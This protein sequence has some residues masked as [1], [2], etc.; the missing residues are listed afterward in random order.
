MENYCKKNER[1]RRM[2]LTPNAALLTTGLLLATSLNVFASE[3]NLGNHSVVNASVTQ[4]GKTI[5]VTVSDE[6]GAL[7]GANV[8]VKGTTNGIMFLQ[9]Q[10]WKFLTLVTRQRKYQ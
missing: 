1:G 3:P 8:I 5:Q 9:M 2:R 4:K 7:I 10:F 6:A